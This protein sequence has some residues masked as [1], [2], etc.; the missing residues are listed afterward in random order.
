VAGTPN[1]TSSTD[2]GCAPYFALAANGGGWIC[3]PA[4]QQGVRLN[5]PG[6]C[7]NAAFA[8][9][10]VYGGSNYVCIDQANIVAG[11]LAAGPSTAS[12][13][14]TAI[15]AAVGLQRGSDATVNGASFA[16]C[17]GDT[18]NGAKLDKLNT[19]VGTFASANH[20]DLLAVKAAG[21]SGAGTVTTQPA[22]TLQT[23]DTSSVIDPAV[24]TYTPVVLLSAVLLAVMLVRSWDFAKRVVSS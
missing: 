17:G 11:D 16:T 24:A 15:C 7:A 13:T 1:G 5:D 4:V 12:S 20:T 10:P 3:L 22:G 19:A 2:A 14:A 8:A 23:G 21:S 6:F 18:A 9:R